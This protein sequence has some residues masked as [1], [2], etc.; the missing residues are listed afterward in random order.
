MKKIYLLSLISIMLG[1]SFSALAGTITMKTNK[2]VGEKLSL[3]LNGDM[4]VNLTWGDGT[5]ET[6]AS[7]GQLREVT[8]KSESLTIT[9]DK[10]ITALYV[11]EDGLTELN[12]SAAPSLKRLFCSDNAL[13]QL[14]LS[15]CTE[16]THLDCQDNQ[17]VGVT[18]GSLKIEH[19]NISGN[20]LRSTGL[21][22]NGVSNIK[23]LLC[24]GNN[25]TTI[26]YLSSMTNMQ[27]FLC[28]NNQL[29]SLSISK[30]K[31]LRDLVAFNNQLVAL[32]TPALPI[33][34][35]LYVDN[36]QL[37]TLDFS[38][39]PGIQHISAGGNNLK[40]LTWANKTNGVYDNVTYVN[41][42]N[43]A[44]F[45]NSFPTIYNYSSRKY[46][47]DAELTPQ[48]P[49]HLMDAANINE[50][51]ALRETF[52]TNGWT[53]G[54]N[55]SLTLTDANGATLESN[56]DYTYRSGQLTFL[57]AH[58]GVVI[59]AESRYYPDITLTTEP[60]NVI[61]PTGISI[62]ENENTIDTGRIYDI[63]GRQTLG[64]PSQKGI[65]I[66]NGKKIVIR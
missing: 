39:N 61:D 5:T 14:D 21:K 2:A 53:A 15:R 9:T 44:L 46:T 56:T 23:S 41:L 40:E 26:S 8:V 24:A 62:V 27:T 7:N 66:V 17:L 58:P 52:V 37:E 36:N 20:Q 48:R 60:F 64:L 28:Q 33:L 16:L 35:N 3:A 38:S 11:C 49:Y 34:F 29:S 43:N 47:M 65:Y 12:V 30:C 18:I 55:A 10:D 42:A 25:M 1:F 63:Q 32:N 57:K 59:S 54:V 45:F 51:Y 31:A 50:A 22:S 19:V 13:T 4:S 6:F